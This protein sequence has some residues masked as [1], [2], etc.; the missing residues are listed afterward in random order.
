MYPARE[1]AEALLAE[2]LPR[3]PGPWGAHSRTAAHCAE[4]IAEA[5]ELVTTF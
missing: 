2:A 1:Q 5:A 3:N 4:K